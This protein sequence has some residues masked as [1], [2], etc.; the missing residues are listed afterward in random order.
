M[1]KSEQLN[2]LFTALSKFQ[3]KMKA[4]S[5]DSNNPFFKS[6]YASLSA[7]VSTAAPI[8]SE[9]GLAVVQLAGEDG[10]ITT[11]LG[12]SSGQ[13]ILTTLKLK[14]AKDDPQGVG[15]ALT[16][17]RR[18]AYAAILGLVSDEDDDGNSAS[19]V[20]GK[21]IQTDKCSQEQISELRDL[22]IEIEET[23]NEGKVAKVFGANS[24]DDLLAKD[25]QKA[26]AVIKAR[27]TQKAKG[28]K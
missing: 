6:K 25:F 8:V 19:Q 18:Y 11:I 15:S 27:K 17:S 4:V 26:L 10:A 5:F 3:G 28:A 9:C 21:P 24:F 7:L 22:L 1:E 16:Y 2:E 20:N 14:P 23:A 13:Y 12:H